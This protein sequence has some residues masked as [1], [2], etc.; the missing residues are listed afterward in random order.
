MNK[1]KY[2]EL[3]PDQYFEIGYSKA[4]EDFRSSDVDNALIK[5]RS[6]MEKTHKKYNIFFIIATV[7]GFLL[8]AYYHSM[9]FYILGVVSF[10]AIGISYVIYS[11]Q[12]SYLGTVQE[13]N[14]LKDRLI[15]DVISKIEIERK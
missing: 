7:V 4:L 5:T 12:T 13:L 2:T 6:E 14:K 15:D 9:G 11:I 3:S 10:V 8:G 1:K